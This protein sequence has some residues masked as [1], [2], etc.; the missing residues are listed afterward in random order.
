MPGRL[1]PDP[2]ALVLRIL[3]AAFYLAAGFF[4]LIAPGGFLRIMPPIVPFPE[5]VVA[6]TGVC[7]IAGAVGLMIPRTRRWAGGMLALY[8]LCVWPANLHHALAGVHVPPLPDSWW[9]HGPRLA[10]QPVLI[11]WALLAGG[12][13]CWPLRPREMGT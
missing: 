9:Y 1:R 12:V 7:E 6:V 4:H 11:W 13:V 3:L 10:F 5:A 8:A 2:L